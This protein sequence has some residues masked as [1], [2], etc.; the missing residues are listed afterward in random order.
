MLCVPGKREAGCPLGPNPRCKAESTVSK[1][2]FF[3]GDE[4]HRTSRPRGEAT[5]D[6]SPGEGMFAKLPIDIQ[7]GAFQHS[8]VRNDNA[9]EGQRLESKTILRVSFGLAQTSYYVSISVLSLGLGPEG[10]PLLFSWH[11]S[12]EGR[13]PLVV[14]NWVGKTLYRSH[15]TSPAGL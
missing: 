4:R 9:A 13:T 6:G 5:F 7:A 1:I 10:T 11:K 8:R 2:Q 12:I 14:S 15:V 3:F